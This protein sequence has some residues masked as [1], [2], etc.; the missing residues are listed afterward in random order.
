M[1]GRSTNRW[2][3]EITRNQPHFKGNKGRRVTVISHSVEGHLNFFCHRTLL[4]FA[5]RRER[6]YEPILVRDLLFVTSSYP[7]C[8]DEL[9]AEAVL[10]PC[11]DNCSRQ[12]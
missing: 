1:L 12:S 6:S 11:A 10:Q 9:C 7:A 2:A 8:L 3:A 5:G 4:A